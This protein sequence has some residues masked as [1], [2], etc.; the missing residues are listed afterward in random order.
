[1]AKHQGIQARG[2]ARDRS[3]DE[4]VAKRAA[5][6][7][8]RAEER[9]GERSS[10]KRR[11][12]K[13]REKRWAS[14]ARAKDRNDGPRVASRA[15]AVRRSSADASKKE[16]E[17]APEPEPEP[18]AGR[19]RG[20]RGRRGRRR[21]QRPRATKKHPPKATPVEEPVAADA[22]ATSPRT[23][24]SRAVDPSADSVVARRRP[25]HAA[26]AAEDDARPARGA[27]TEQP[28][29]AGAP[30]LEEAPD[31]KGKQR[32]RVR[33]VVNL[34]RAGAVQ[35]RQITRDRSGQRT[36]AASRRVALEVSRSTRAASAGMQARAHRSVKPDLGARRPGRSSVDGRDQRRR[37][38]KAARCQ[39]APADSGASSWR[40]A[41]MVS[42]NQTDRCRDER[43]KVAKEFGYEIQDTGFKEEEFLEPGT[44]A[45]EGRRGRRRGGR[46]RRQES[47]AAS[48]G[49]HRHGSRRPRQDDAARHAAQGR[50]DSVADG[51]AGVASPST[52]APTRPSRAVAT[53]ITF[54]DTPGHAAFTADACP[55]REALTDLVVLVVAANDGVM[56]QTVEAIEHAQSGRRARS[57]WRST[58]CDLPERRSPTADP[59]A[60]DGAQ[61]RA[62][63]VRW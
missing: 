11:P 18:E 4:I 20:R 8:H 2:R 54:I 12:I 24:P 9:D 35:A 40:S 26:A 63:R 25:S 48:A 50:D 15:R 31:R 7:R 22:E 43:V 33:E 14:A 1:M 45:G 47:A 28:G 27:A 37:A 16:S 55:R 19:R 6:H 39:K 59:P 51:E 29:G 13:L 21:R 42:I 3:K 62:R 32:K 5:A 60:S 30:G 61:S 34:Q 38:R 52:S 56:P 41:S 23:R 58:R 36:P 10:P 53:R 17:P 44:A 57:S 46:G 49:G